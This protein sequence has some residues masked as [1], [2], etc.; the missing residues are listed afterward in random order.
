MAKV[1][2][3]H[4]AST[5][6]TTGESAVGGED[7]PGDGERVYH[8]NDAVKRG[9]RSRRCSARSGQAKTESIAQ[10]VRD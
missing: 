3:W 4:P 2:P 10:R 8:D 9:T 5:A 1:E 7:T 6:F